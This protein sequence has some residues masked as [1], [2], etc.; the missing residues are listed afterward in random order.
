MACRTQNLVRSARTIVL[1]S[2][3]T[4]LLTVWLCTLG[5]LSHSGSSRQWFDAATIVVLLLILFYAEGLELAIADLLDKQPDQLTDLRMRDLLR[6]IQRDGDFFF[7]T[8]QVFV[9]LIITYMSLATNYEWI[10]LPFIGR[11]SEHEAPFW[12]SLLFTSFTVLWFCQV[13]P[14]RLA[15]MNSE[16]FLK[17]SAFLW[18]LIKM[19]GLLGLPSPS[20]DL[21][22]IFKR[23]TGYRNK[24]HLRPSAAAHFNTTSNI[25]GTSLDQVRVE[26]STAKSGLISIKKRYAVLFLSGRRSCHE[27]KIYFR[28]SV[29]SPPKVT[30]LGLY[31]TAIP[32]R[33]EMISNNMDK[34]FRNEEPPD[35]VMKIEE[36]SH[37]VSVQVDDDVFHGGQWIS[38]IIRSA[39][40]LPESLHWT[41]NPETDYKTLAAVLIYE[42]EVI[43][44]EPALRASGEDFEQVW[45]EFFESPCRS[46]TLVLRG[47]EFQQEAGFHYCDVRLKQGSI[48]LTDETAKCT[49]LAVAASRSG[50][51]KIEYPLQ[52]ATYTVHWCNLTSRRTPEEIDLQTNA[53]ING[54]SWAIPAPSQTTLPDPPRFS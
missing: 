42:I 3:W 53:E 5:A 24:R 23:F 4:L 52:G 39:Q 46:Y 35:E 27:E 25:Y 14:K 18:P 2:G 20:D 48:V 30:I 8:R 49:K 41:A 12:F 47:T 7:S 33:L 10:F 44:P 26:I 17:H 19:T 6:E 34:I 13:T 16:L 11:Y 28:S 43:V 9:V 31:A 37:H 21:V 54:Q 36:W 40:P 1:W 22:W 32:E 51:L 15:V 29:A 50:I 45:P 38:W